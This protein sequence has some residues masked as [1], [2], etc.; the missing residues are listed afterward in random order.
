MKILRAQIAVALA[1][2]GAAWGQLP[3][4]NW[5]TDLS[6]RSID[7]SELR[8]GGPPKDGI[9]A[10][11]RP[12]FVSPAAAA[13][14]LDSKEPVL[15]VER[16]GE[17]RAY[18][19]QILIWHEL[20]NDTIGGVPI[21][22]SYCPLCNSAIVFDRRVDGE[23]YSFGVSGLLRESDMVMYDR[24]TD[25]LWQQVT[26]EAIVGTLTGKRL[27]VVPSQTVA[28][29][30]F[31]RAFP[32]GKVLSR[33][34][35]RRRPYG[36]NPYVGY[37]FGGFLFEPN[38][39]KG[40]KAPKERIVVVEAGGE[41]TAY[42]FELLRREGVVEGV[43]GGR[44]YVIFHQR[45]TVTPLDRSRI[46][47]SRDVGSVGVFV[48]E[49]DGRRLTFRRKKG[50]IIDRE[51][52]SEWN[53]LGFAVNGPLEGERLEPVPHGVYFAFA[54]LIFNPETELITTAAQARERIRAR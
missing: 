54:W 33:E 29:G 24:A 19:F 27:R 26:G 12:K 17:A 22:V 45:G 28:F 41:A 10:I 13:E 7:L 18:P 9:P 5:R 23:T 40:L 16:A 8:R 21:L 25:S 53:V 52:G 31:A 49:I 38:V 14:W 32:D 35:G 37:E 47:D 39:P 1:L 4:G 48:P 44:R 6:K 43:T 36:T 20:V 42:S 46:A 30:D 34:T 15:V 3:E 2:A 51:T 50:R 11:D